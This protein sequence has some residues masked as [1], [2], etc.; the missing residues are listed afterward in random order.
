MAMR[1]PDSAAETQ[2]PVRAHH[3]TAADGVA[4]A[5]FGTLLVASALFSRAH[6]RRE[7]VA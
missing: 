2:I 6:R 3:A 5:L 4:I 7:V 1:V